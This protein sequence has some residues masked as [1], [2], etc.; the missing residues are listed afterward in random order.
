MPS[1]YPALV[2]CAER[3]EA[4][5]KAAT[6]AASKARWD[7]RSHGTRRFVAALAKRGI[8]AKETLIVIKGERGTMH[9]AAVPDAP[10]RIEW[11]GNDVSTPNRNDPK[12]W[13][14]V[15]VRR[16]KKRG[17]FHEKWETLYAYGPTPEA[18]AKMVEKW[19]A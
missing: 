13:F 9:R 14:R 2:R 5:A 12:W 3:L 10:G 4:K 16:Q 6:E 17:G 1:T 15:S 7:I 11:F 8:H 19:N 18:A